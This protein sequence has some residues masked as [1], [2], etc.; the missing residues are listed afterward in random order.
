MADTGIWIDA[1]KNGTNVA[2]GA[3]IRI[4]G[5]TDSISV[6][7]VGQ[8]HDVFPKSVTV[9]VGNGPE[10]TA[11]ALAAQWASWETTF[12]R[13]TAGPVTITATATYLAPGNPTHTAKI[14]VT[15]VPTAVTLVQPSAPIGTQEFTV[16]V[17]A[18]HP[19]GITGTRARVDGQ[20]W[21]ELGAGGGPGT[22]RLPSVLVP[23]GGHTA[24]V[25]ME[26]S[27]GDGSVHTGTASVQT[28]DA[29]DPVILAV[30][31]GDGVK[32]PGTVVGA[33]VPVSVTVRDAGPGQL[34][35]G[36]SAVTVQVDAGTPVNA[37]RTGSGDPSGWAATVFVPGADE[38]TIIV[39]TTDGAGRSATPVTHRLVVTARVDLRDLTR[40]TYLTDLL[41]FTTERLRTGSPDGGTLPPAVTVGQLAEALAQDLPAVLRM[42]P[43]DSAAPTRTLRLVTE[44]LVR[45]MRPAHPAPV[46]SWP[47][48]DGQGDVAADSAGGL[49]QGTVEGATWM[50]GKPPTLRFDPAAAAR[51]RVT[52]QAS[53]QVRVRDGVTMVA[54]IRPTA[55]TAGPGVIVRK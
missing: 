1:P 16:Q 27:S 21:V 4:A 35:S 18:E 38:H 5:G 37:V 13:T 50:P 47:L 43:A 31:P 3:T 8:E 11:T 45:Y 41:A 39:R 53:A 14:T 44:S 17:H 19:A 12:R 29:N 33:N 34:T 42:P 20:G 23:P 48:D 55:P 28:V 25:D 6:G 49:A 32:I 7:A 54:R 22:L 51:V 26:A 9:S 2:L 36:V 15:A 52:A 24:V 40:E 30:T 10:E 46:A